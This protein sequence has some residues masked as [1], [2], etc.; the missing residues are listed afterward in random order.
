MSTHTIIGLD[1]SHNNFLTLESP[2]YNEFT[3]FFFTSGYKLGKIQAGFN[4]L[5]DLKKY[6]VI[7][8]ST[9]KNVKLKQGEIEIIKKYVR[10]G[11][12]L[13]C[14]SSSGGDATNKTNLNELT[15]NFGFE[16][17]SDE[18]Y[19]SFNY[20]NLQKRPII[21]RFKH[22]MI[23]EQ[24]SKIVFSSACSTQI[25]EFPENEKNIKIDWLLESGLNGWRKRYDGED[26]IEEDCPKTP[27]LVVSEYY[28][29]KIV[30]FGNLSI[31]SSL[32]A[33][34]YGF[35]AF[36][37]EILISN[38]FNFLIGDRD[39]QGKRI[40]I[41]LNLELYYWL[42]SII[43]QEKW[44]KKSD[45]INV[46]LQYFKDNYDEIIE[47]I[48]KNRLE[49]IEKRKAYRKAKKDV[50]AEKK[51]EEIILDKV[52]KIVRKKEDLEDIMSALEEITGERYELSIDLEKKEEETDISTSSLNYT[53]EEIKEF[54]ERHPKKAIW[55]GKPTKSFRNWLI[56]KKKKL[57]FNS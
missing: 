42:D 13:L 49:R 50:E 55:H 12:N 32:G 51:A 35:S 39:S 11:G 38:I 34:D 15:R 37:N 57:D 4:S 33:R 43:K 14:I 21:N 26:W 56:I 1:Y 9:P 19:D 36:D 45:L 22:H 8:L 6:R 31:F 52:P 17:G 27:L 24:I 28:K 25:L 23:T 10:N 44:E 16:F 3:Q 7:F 20:I 41:E 2:S 30:G 18:I 48:K 29:G 40:N 5:E 47:D 54:E 53:K 46:S